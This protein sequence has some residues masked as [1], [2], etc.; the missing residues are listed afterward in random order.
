MD[1]QFILAGV[2]ENGLAIGYSR[3]VGNL[4]IGGSYTGSLVNELFQRVTNQDILTLRKHDDLTENTASTTLRDQNDKTPSGET[5]SNNDINV[6]VGSGI[7]GIRLGFSE[8]LKSIEDRRGSNQLDIEDISS[9]ESSF[10]PTLEMGLNIPVGAVRVKPALRGAFDIH[11]YVNIT[12][13]E[14]DYNDGTGDHYRIERSLLL[15][16]MEPSGGLSL[17]LDFGNS[18]HIRAEMILSG[19]I[20]FRLYNTND[21]DGGW[22]N[23]KLADHTLSPT[24]GS[25]ETEFLA[26][27]IFDLRLSGAPS[28]V[29]S[30][31]LTPKFTLGFKAKVDFGFNLLEITQTEN[32][33]TYPGGIKTYTPG[34]E[35]V[36]SDTVFSVTPDFGLGVSY[37]LIPDHFALHAG[38]GIVLFSYR[39]VKTEIDGGATR[40][41]KDMYLPSTKLAAGLTLNFTETVAID[42]M[43]IMSGLT[44]DSTKIT[45]LVTVKQ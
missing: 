33:V 39:E 5:I 26:P 34:P 38:L 24:P 10:K 37:K 36:T 7:F 17:G 13:W 8:Y 35:Y 44:F 1:N 41:V 12:E 16:Y 11:Q 22:V 14:R 28:F 2:D 43:A 45:A 15:D 19:D 6:I 9:F 30:G 40:T 21:N 18:E 31:D 42:L 27:D 3:R 25:S 20:A 29:F 32:T 23:Y 4:Y